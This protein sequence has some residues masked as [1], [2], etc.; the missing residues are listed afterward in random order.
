MNGGMITAG[1]SF[2]D[3]RDKAY[4]TVDTA[5]AE[6]IITALEAENVLFSAKYNGARISLIFSS[7]DTAA[8]EKIIQK[9]QND[10]SDMLQ[11]QSEPGSGDDEYKALFPEIARLLNTSISAL[12]RHPADQQ[13]LLT[14]VYKNYCYA[15][16]TTIREALRSVIQLNRETER[17]IDAARSAEAAAN[18]TPAKRTGISEEEKRLATSALTEQ[19]IIQ[20]YADRQ[21]QENNRRITISRKQLKQTA[22]RISQERSTPAPEQEPED[23]VRQK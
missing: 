9:A 4:K 16:D 21:A 20:E 14:T 13:L 19:I 11:R 17:D 22:Q 12:E 10:N 7:D 8:V 6:Q 23:I 1:Y 3:I 5:K 15:D 2:R 18:N